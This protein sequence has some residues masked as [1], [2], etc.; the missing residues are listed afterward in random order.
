MIDRPLL[1]A[2]KHSERPHVLI[3]TDDPDLATFLN[4]GLPLGGFWTT[5]I[6]SGLQV[7]EV[8]RL[9]QFDLII[10]DYGLR[11][12]GAEE[13]MLRLRGASSRIREQAPRTTAPVVVISV[14]PVE[15]SDESMQTMGISRMLHAPIDL[16]DLVPE[17]HAVFEEWREAYPTMPLSDDPTR[18]NR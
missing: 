13:L 4:E 3:V 1:K 18:P 5:V 10:V 15:L 14:D 16:E 11:S 17:L 9:R 12:F 7:L 6:S 8:F 2:R